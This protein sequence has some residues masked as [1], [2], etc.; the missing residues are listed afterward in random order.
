M[1]KNVLVILMV[2]SILFAEEAE[3]V[4]Q[5]EFPNVRIH[6]LKGRSISPHD[7]FDKKLTLVNFW[8]TWCVPCLKEMKYLNQF[9]E[10]YNKEGFHVVGISIDDTRT[11]RRVLSVIKSKHITYPIYLDTEQALFQRFQCSAMPFSVLVSSEG[12]ILWEH[13]GYIPGD[14]K[15]ME[16]IILSRLRESAIHEN[17]EAVPGKD[18]DLLEQK[19]K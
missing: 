9:H 12:M 18:E 19:S 14:E 8:A 5:T 4:K 10:K 2:L 13:T 6:T 7:I 16:R 1:M 3:K 17:A 15:E 11:S